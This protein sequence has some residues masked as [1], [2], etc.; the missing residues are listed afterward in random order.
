MK[1]TYYI[2]T[3]WG[4]LHA[5]NDFVAGYILTTYTFNHVSQQN[6]LALIVYAIIGFGGQLPV[7]MFLDDQRNKGKKSMV[8]LFSKV[9][10]ALILFSILFYF[11]NS[12]FAIIIAGFSSAFLHVCGGSICLSQTKEKTSLLGIFTAPG[13]LGLTAGIAFSHIPNYI[14]IIP[15]LIVTIILIYLIKSNNY[16]N[17]VVIY[18]GLPAKNKTAQN[19]ESHDWLMLAILLI[20]TMRSLIYDIINNFSTQLPQGLLLIGLSAFTGKIIGGF[21]A[22]K[23]GWRNWVY[24]TLPLAF[25]FLQ[26]GTNNIY[27]L[28]FG[29]ACLQSSLPISIMLMNKNLPKFTATST[30]FILGVSVV[31]AGLP[32]YLFK[33][34]LVCNFWFSKTGFSISFIAIILI[35]YFI[36]KKSKFFNQ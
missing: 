23:I 4:I 11:I 7:G 25:I 17:A 29:I 35:I 28:S 20:A 5:L 10:L 27:M 34:N 26:L 33:P 13:V 21:F 1:K 31:F 9:S 36:A 24:I 6:A 16:S 8:H 18:S 32:L 3:L 15:F 19:L 14:L 12:F 30:A 2:A 22:D